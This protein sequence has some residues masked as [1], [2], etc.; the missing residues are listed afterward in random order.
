MGFL[1]PQ[2]RGEH[3]VLT[4][5]ALQQLAQL[6]TTVVGL[7]DQ[8]ARSVPSASALN[9]TGLLRHC[10]QVAVYW[11]AAAAAAPECPQVPAEFGDEETL[12]DC[13]ADSSTLAETLA[14]FDRCVAF[15]AQQLQAATDLDA[16]VP[17]PE[18]PWFPAEL[19]SWDARWAIAHIATE[20]AR[21]TGHADII[22]ETIDGKGA[23]ELNDL[24]DAAR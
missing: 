1:T 20:V 12:E 23:Y 6:R 2:A 8:Q 9:L 10:G 14:Y 15:A 21:H 22:R 13:V 18:A 5:Y 19:G 17:V 3:A 24:A 4:V 16:Q 7:T 11:S